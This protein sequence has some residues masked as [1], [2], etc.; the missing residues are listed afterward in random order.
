MMKKNIKSLLLS[1]VA[2]LSLVSCVKDDD[3]AIP[4]I[5]EYLYK[6]GFET[7]WTDWTKVSVTGAQEWQLDTQYGNPGNCAKMSGFASGNNVNEDWLIS[8]VIDLSSVDGAL[9]SF[10]TASKFSG[11]PLEVKISTDYT[12]GDPT[13]A[14]WTDVS[15][16]LDLD[17]SNYVWTNSG[18]IDISS[19][20]G[21]NVRLAFKYTSTS[22]ASTTWEIDNIKILKN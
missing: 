20:T 12:S 6:D 7:S 5:Y 22:S 10:Q 16:N 11:N 19:F 21:T 3:Y 4:T 1:T 18:N 9:L 13:S 14:T 15:G 2:C 8:P 17:T